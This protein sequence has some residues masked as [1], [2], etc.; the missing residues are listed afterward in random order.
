[1]P[2]SR[3]IKFFL[4]KNDSD[5]D[6]TESCYPTVTDLIRQDES[7]TDPDMPSMK[8]SEELPPRRRRGSLTVGEHAESLESIRQLIATHSILIDECTTVSDSEEG[9]ANDLDNDDTANVKEIDQ[10]G[11]ERLLEERLEGLISDQGP[12]DPEFTR[13]TTGGGGSQFFPG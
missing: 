1:M 3:G 13:Y 4:R 8:K 7:D 5:T 2:C 6:V 10:V 12:R 9:G 11:C